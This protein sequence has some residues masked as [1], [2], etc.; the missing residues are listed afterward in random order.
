[1]GVRFYITKTTSREASYR[2]G[3]KNRVSMCRKHRAL[4]TA[5]KTPMKS[6]FRNTETKATRLDQY[7]NLK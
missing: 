1:M 6:T 7:Y 3:L 5:Q 2:V 4:S